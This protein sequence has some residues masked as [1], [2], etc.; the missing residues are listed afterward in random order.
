MYDREFVVVLNFNLAININLLT[1]IQ[2][3]RK[4]LNLQFKQITTN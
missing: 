3:L 2:E 4:L 1:W